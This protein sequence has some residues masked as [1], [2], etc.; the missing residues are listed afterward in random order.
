MAFAP[1]DDGETMSG[2]KSSLPAAQFQIL[3]ALL[4]GPKH[5]FAINE[6]IRSRSGGAIDMG[7]GTLYGG[8]KRL[9][10][11]G[12]IEVDPSIEDEKSYRVTVK[13][14]EAARGEVHR[15]SALVAIA[16]DKAI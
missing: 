16:T 10:R 9:L 12:W 14:Y 6:D 11:R 8:L 2:E 5:G 7:P 1:N 3:L 13:G 15:M 4:D